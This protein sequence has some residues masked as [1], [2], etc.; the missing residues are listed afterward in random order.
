L[1]AINQSRRR[2]LIIPA[3][4]FRRAADTVADEFFPEDRLIDTRDDSK[5]IQFNDHQRQQRPPA[6]VRPSQRQDGCDA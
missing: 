3:Q 2:A 5:M 4:V 6:S 1:A